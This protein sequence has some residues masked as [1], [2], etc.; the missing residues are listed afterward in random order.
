[1]PAVAAAVALVPPD[2]LSSR[3]A[4]ANAVHAN[5]AAAGTPSPAP[6]DNH[7]NNPVPNEPTTPVAAAG[8]AD[9]TGAAAAAAAGTDAAPAD[10]TDAGTPDTAAD[11]ATAAGDSFL[12]TGTGT[13][14][15]V[16]DALGPGT[17]TSTPPAPA[18]TALS[19]P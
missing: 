2:P 6:P 19:P 15:G 13:E 9:I 5:G 10:I 18:G 14:A 7:A 1:M 16:T 3:R 11:G 8:A 4:A 17:A 12:T